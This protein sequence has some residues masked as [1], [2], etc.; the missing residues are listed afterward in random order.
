[1]FIS[2]LAQKGKVMPKTAKR[3]KPKQDSYSQ[4]DKNIHYLDLSEILRAVKTHFPNVSGRPYPKKI[5]NVGN[6]FHYRVNWRD[7]EGGFTNSAFI[8]IEKTKDGLVLTDE[9]KNA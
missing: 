7:D 8:R 4:E 3:T 5:S 9:T 1:M 6:L 2:V